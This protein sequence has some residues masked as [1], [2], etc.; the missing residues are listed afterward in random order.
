MREICISE[1]RTCAT[2]SSS[3]TCAVRVRLRLRVG[4]RVRVRV[5]V[6]VTVTVRVGQPPEAFAGCECR[7]HDVTHAQPQRAWYVVV[8]TW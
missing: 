2:E 5:G 3:C 7:E 6:T 4:V 1:T 8:S